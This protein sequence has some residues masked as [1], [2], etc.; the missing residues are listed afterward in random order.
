MLLGDRGGC[1]YHR[2]VEPGRAVGDACPDIDIHIDWRVNATRDRDGHID[3]VVAH[4]ADVV[5]MQ[6]PAPEIMLEHLRQLQRQGVAVVVEIDDLLSAISPAHVGYR[7]YVR[8]GIAARVAACAAEADWVTVSTPA[9][10][11]TY[12]RHGRV[13]VIPNA[14]PRH[15]AELPPAYDRSPDVVTVGW[16][17]TVN[18]H[19][20]DL[21]ELASGL[22]Q[23][24]E[25][26]PGRS[27]FA[28]YS[29]ADQVAPKVG[30]RPD[31]I[32]WCADPA[33]FLA[34]V[35][36]QLDVGIAPLRED[37]F[38]AAKSWLKPLE[39]A[40]RGVLPIRSTTG[41]YERAGIGV[42][43]KRPRDW[44]RLLTRAI[45]DKDWRREQAAAARQQVLER[46]LTEHTAE[47]WAAA[48]R[49]AADS[50]RARRVAA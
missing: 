17:A 33:D 31:E 3:H 16:T 5:V 15:I 27:R 4:G 50:R 20:H 37:R 12:G 38:N 11:A 49:S 6:R 14:I 41:E 18:S 34:S 24:I 29:G 22:R 10:A 28:V 39:Y 42:A 13:S 23:A 44:A 1:A 45:S 32:G 9:L 26:T 36:E 40:A 35:G 2:M 46:H 25:S 47:A 30:V 8:G 7:E 19:P 48:W 21:D 43:A